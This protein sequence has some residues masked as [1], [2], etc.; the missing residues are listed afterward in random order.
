MGVVGLHYFQ[1]PLHHVQLVFGDSG[2]AD[3]DSNQGQREQTNVPR[4]AGH[5]PVIGFLIYFGGLLAS[6]IAAFKSAEHANDRRLFWWFVPFFCFLGLAYWFAS[7]AIVYL[8][9]YPVA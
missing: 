3:S 2:S 9:K 1:L 7:H 4:P 5:Y 8:T 6:V